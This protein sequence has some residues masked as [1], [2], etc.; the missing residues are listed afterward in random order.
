ML[1]KF[2]NWLCTEEA[3]I[4]IESTNTLKL[5]SIWNKLLFNEFLSRTF[6]SVY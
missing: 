5:V 2:R 3:K 6:V 4:F 1:E